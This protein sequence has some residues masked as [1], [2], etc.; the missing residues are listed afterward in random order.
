MSKVL[1]IFK[2]QVGFAV[3]NIAVNRIREQQYLLSSHTDIRTKY[4]RLIILDVLSVNI[5]SALR[6]IVK[7]RYKVHQRCF[8]R[9]CRTHYYNG[10]SVPDMKIYIVKH[11]NIS[12]FCSYVPELYIAVKTGTFLAVMIILYMRTCIVYIYYL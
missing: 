9:T 8:S 4:I 7:S 1:Y 12:E 5:Y 6:R 3:G 10:F 11:G 2:K